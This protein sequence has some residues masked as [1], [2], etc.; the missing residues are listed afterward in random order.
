MM[1][2]AA[3]KAPDVTYHTLVKEGYT[4]ATIGR[5]ITKGLDEAGK[6]LDE[7]MPRWGMD[8][9]DLDATIAYLKVLSGR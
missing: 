4:S 8:S 6:P 2:G 5:A 3:I 7:A 9:A 1:M